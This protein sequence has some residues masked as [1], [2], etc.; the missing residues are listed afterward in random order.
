MRESTLNDSFS[1]NSLQTAQAFCPT[2]MF[3][4][5]GKTD[6]LFSESDHF[7]AKYTWLCCQSQAKEKSSN[8]GMDRLVVLHALFTT[9]GYVNSH[10]CFKMWICKYTLTF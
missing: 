6:P 2:S 1:I 10:L 7:E 4:I 3:R 5:R 9:Q 8:T